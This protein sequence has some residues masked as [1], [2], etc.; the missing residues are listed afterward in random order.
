M[1]EVIKETRIPSFGEQLIGI[2]I[3][4]QEETELYK[5]NYAFAE[6]VEKVKKDYES[7]KN[8][9]KSMLFDQAVAQVLAAKLA[10]E[11]YMKYTPWDSTEKNH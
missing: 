8:P 7:A 4:N 6:I 11:N 10:V 9:M 3:D 5:I 1:D 2:S